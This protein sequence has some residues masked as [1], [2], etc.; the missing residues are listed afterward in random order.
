MGFVSVAANWNDMSV[1]LRS[2]RFSISIKLA[3]AAINKNLRGD[4]TAPGRVL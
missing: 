2:G 1:M 4:N 3:H